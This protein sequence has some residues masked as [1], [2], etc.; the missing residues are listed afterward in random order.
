MLTGAIAGRKKSLDLRMSTIPTYR[1]RRNGAVHAYTLELS[2]WATIA[3][4]YPTAGW[5]S[6]PAEDKVCV[7][8]RHQ[9]P[10][11]ASIAK[12]YNKVSN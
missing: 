8:L 10:R 4:R 1:H 12:A 6:H 2:A 11:L 7:Y 5:W 9:S 3:H